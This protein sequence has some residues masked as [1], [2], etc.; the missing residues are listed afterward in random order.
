MWEALV[1]VDQP[2]QVRRIQHEHDGSKN[3]PLWNSAQKKGDDGKGC[4]AADILR[5]AVEV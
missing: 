5:A 4:I 3:R 1:F 2:Q